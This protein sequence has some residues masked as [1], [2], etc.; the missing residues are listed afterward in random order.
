MEQTGSS[1]T[2]QELTIKKSTKNTVLVMLS[3]FVSRMLGFA[4][5]AVI[6]SIFGASGK[7]DVLNSV[8]TIPNNLRKLMAEGALSSAFIPALSN[9]LVN[10]PSG[11]R[12]KSIVRNILTFQIVVLVPFCV[13]SIIFAD[14]LIRFV[15][16]DFDTAEQVLLAV[17]LFRWFITYLLLI[18]ISAAMMGTLNS[19]N[20][21]FVPALTPMLFSAAVIS[22]ILFLHRYLGVF[23]M[24]VGVITGGVLQILFQMPK[25]HALGYSFKPDF[26][27]SNPDFKKILRNWL[28]V[29]ATSSIF[30]IN[31]QIAVRFA[32]GLDIGS[33]SALHYAL[34]FFQLPF[35][36]FSASITTVLFPR[37]SKQAGKDDTKGLMESI[38][39]GIRFLLLTLIPSAFILAILGNEIISVA[40]FRGQFTLEATILTGRVLTAYVLGLFSVGAF[41]FLQRF[42]YSIHNYKLPFFL[43]VI[44]AVIDIAFSLW[45]KETYLG[46]VGLALANTI[47]FTIGCII[48]V[49]IVRMKLGGIKG[50]PILISFLKV[51]ISS[52]VSGV[53]IF[54]V[55]DIF[56]PWWQEGSTVLGFGILVIEGVLSFGII[57]GMYFL[58]KVDIFINM[59]EK[60]KKK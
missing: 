12:S 23:S 42:F 41:N 40:M 48:S 45:L 3:T 46:V 44:V 36:I 15:L 2:T 4:R 24:V 19:H 28:P 27:F 47:A 26:R 1:E 13:L 21:F 6:G 37:M 53:F 60:K 59:L 10:D 50:K 29:V 7:A 56:G 43:A 33:A 38:Q 39:Y 30:T 52:V 32:T 8:F 34:V 35:G 9:S 20:E 5:I 11:K 58:L 14:P 31:Q 17:R 49:S 54:I 55:K 51:L 57:L 22:S 25:F 16:V 18:S